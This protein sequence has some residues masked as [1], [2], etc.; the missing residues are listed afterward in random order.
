MILAI[1]DV[2][3][4]VHRCPICRETITIP[5][6]GVGNFPPSFIVN[7]LLDLMASQRRDIIPKCSIHARQE[8]LFCET[9]DTVFC[10]DCTGGSHNGRGASAHTVIPFSIA[11]KR[12]SEILLYKASLCMRNLDN[13]SLIVSEEMSKL[14][15]AA[16]KCMEAVSKAFSELSAL[17]DQRRLD[18]LKMVKDVREE[19]KKVLQEQL[20]I[21]D[22]EKSKVQDDCHGLQHQI[23]VRNITKKISDLNEKLD[24]S[25]TLAEPREN[26][27]MKFE[28]KH[29]S[30]LCDVSR[31]MAQFGHIKISKTFP[32]LCRASVD[33][34]ISM[35]L[36]SRV[37]LETVDYHG[38]PRTSGSDPVAVE[39]RNETGDLLQTDLQ[40]QEDGTYL[41]TFTPRA[42]G[43]HKLY[44]SV[45]DRP[46]RDSPFLITVSE[47][48]NPVR[49]LGQ[50]GSGTHQ[51]IQPVSAAINGV[52]DL[53]VLDAGNSRIRHHDRNGRFLGN[54]ES[55]VGL[56][57]HSCT[58]MA[59]TVRDSLLLVNWRTRQVT[60]ISFS[61][62]VL[63]KFSC[64]E[65]QEPTSIAINQHGE[66]IVGD[67]GAGKLFVFDPQ[68]NL[69]HKVGSKGNNLGQF[70][71]IT[72]VCCTPD[73]DILVTDTRLQ[74]FSRT[75]KFKEEIGQGSKVKGQYGGVTLDSQGNILATRTEKGRSFVQIFDPE[76]R[77]KCE[78]DSHDDKL[79]RPSGLATWQDGT[80]AVVDLGN[81]CVKVF[82]YM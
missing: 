34:N 27:F 35:H 80:V 36:E 57:Q 42:A 48:N 53:F 45:F 79:K 82:R 1:N 67:N 69:L 73:D 5:R 9:C 49:R 25:S 2:F 62:Q 39:L 75:G 72:S 46:V 6:G 58:G 77:F 70:K 40:D 14:D 15:T 10:V 76:K 61:G 50:R 7:Q 26:A 11:I 8:L 32:A 4:F 18:V 20:Q 23:E 59:L 44:I 28:H 68:G 66:I 33:R 12:M 38:N 22:A 16:E 47:H 29:N 81:D 41:I 56:E 51:F 52:G 31:A 30:A 78:L 71:V 21:I 63:H 37:T 13:A 60:E 64:P 17:V 54:I 24:M 43:Q 3:S 65:F 55:R 74:L 19:K